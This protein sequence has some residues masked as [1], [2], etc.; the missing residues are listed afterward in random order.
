M[1]HFALLIIAVGEELPPPD[2]TVIVE[3]GIAHWNG[4]DWI[5]ENYYDGARVLQGVRWWA[6]LPVHPFSL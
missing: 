3:G 4:K 5:S 6:R 1:L 2:L